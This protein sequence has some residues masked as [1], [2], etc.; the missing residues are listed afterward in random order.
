MKI[1]LEMSLRHKKKNLIIKL[2][3]PLIGWTSLALQYLRIKLNI[4]EPTLLCYAKLYD[5][6]KK[7]GVEKKMI[8][9]IKKEIQ[10]S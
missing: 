6:L 1:M 4:I 5:R 8:E 2:S 9:S 7:C 3:L 10:L